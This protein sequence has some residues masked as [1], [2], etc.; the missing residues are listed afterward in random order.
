[1]IYCM[2]HLTPDIK[3]EILN[4]RLKGINKKVFK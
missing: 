3:V 4:T 1:M 2:M